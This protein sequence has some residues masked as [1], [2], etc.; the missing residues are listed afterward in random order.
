MRTMTRRSLMETLGVFSAIA[1]GGFRPRRVAATFC[2][3]ELPE[4]AGERI[5]L[6]SIAHGLP[7]NAPGQQ[8]HL[9]R[10]TLPPREE[11][12]AHSHP[13]ATMLEIESGELAYTVL[14]GV[15]RR[16][17]TG[18][19]GLRVELLVKTGETAVFTPGDA[20]Y[21]DADT[22]HTAVNPGDLPVAVIAVTLLD[23]AQPQTIPVEP[24]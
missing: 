18:E 1:S 7:S 13:G 17:T 3:T 16:W 20:I 2:D 11:L 8:L 6:H 23:M 15:V 4:G 14:R 9:Y 10:F 12:P 22:A 19:D 21:Y 5:T 24:D